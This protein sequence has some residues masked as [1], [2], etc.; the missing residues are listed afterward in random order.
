[1]SLPESALSSH[2]NATPAG[3]GWS[4]ARRR[5]GA[6]LYILLC[7]EIGTFLLILPWSAIW[8]RNLLLRLYPTLRPVFIS[9]YLRGAVSGLGLINIWLGVSQAWR[10]KSFTAARS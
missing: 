5:L 8:D 4:I 3:R 10:F 2:P 6:V 7:I 9:A 1:M